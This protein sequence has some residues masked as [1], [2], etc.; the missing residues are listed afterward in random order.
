MPSRS[1]RHQHARTF[2]RA[3]LFKEL[4]SFADLERHIEQL[5]TEKE[6]GD[7]FEVFVEAYLC[8]DEMAQAEEVWVVGQIPG[9]VARQLNFPSKDYGFDGVV[10]TKLGEL[11]PYQAKFRTGRASLPYAELATFFGITE[12]A[13]R[14][15][16]LTNSMAISAVAESRTGFQTTRGGDFDR[17]DAAQLA[18]IAAWIDGV[19]PTPVIREPRPHQQAALAEIQSELSTHDRA[20]V[21]MAC[22]T[23]KTLV[24]LWAAERQQP[25]RVLVLVPSLSLLRQTLHEWAKWTN[26]G[27]R[28]RYLC[29]C[30]D[31]KVAKGIDEIEIRPEDADFPVMTDPAVVGRFLDHGEG[32]VSVVFCTYQSA[33]VVGAAMADRE[34][35]DLGIFDEAHKTT[36][37]EGTRFAFALRDENLPIR[38][39][40]FMTAT[41]RHYDIR[42]RDKE[43][44]FAVASMDDE[45]VYGRVAHRL[46]FANAA[47]QKI[48]VPY[49]VV[50]SVVDSEMIDNALLDQSEVVING[51]PVR[52]KWV[53]HQI[54]LKRAV[55]EH[56]LK[57]VISF[58]SS[59]KAAVE[60]ASDGSA[61]VGTH[62]PSFQRFHV[63]GAQPTAEREEHMREFARVQRGVITN[64]RCLTEGVD[65]PSVDMVAFM[66]PRRSRVDIVQAVG[67]AMR[68]AGLDKTCGYVLI[69]LFLETRK[70]ESLEEALERSDFDEVAQVLNAMRESDDDLNDI[71]Q[72]LTVDRGRIG[73]FDESRLR[74]KLE[75]LGPQL[76][77]AELAK[78]VGI[79]LV[80][81]LGVTWDERYGQLIAYK[82]HHGTCNVPQRWKLVQGLGAW[83]NRQRSDCAKGDLS[84]D[85][86]ERLDRLGFEWE[87]FDV[88]WAR[89]FE[90]LV[91]YKT[92]NGNLNVPKEWKESPR[93]GNWCSTQRVLYSR[94]QLSHSRVQRLEELGFRWDTYGDAWEKMFA[95]LVAYKQERGN[96]NVSKHNKG[97][98]KLG[99]WCVTQRRLYSKHKLSPACVERLE[100]LG[101]LW[102]PFAVA[103]ERMLEALTAY[104][105]DYGNC[106]VPRSFDGNRGLGAWCH[107][108][109]HAYK[110]GKLPSEYASRLEQLGFEW[111]PTQS[112]WEQMFAALSAYKAVHGN[113]DVPDPYPDNPRLGRWC[114]FQ[115]HRLTANKLSP[116]RVKRLEQLG[117]SWDPFAASW[118]EMFE[119]LIAFWQDHG[120]CAV[121]AHW[122]ENR[123]LGR[124]CFRQRR[125]WRSNRLPLDRVQRLEQVGFVFESLGAP[126][127][128]MFSTLCAYKQSHGDCDVPSGLKTNPRLASWCLKQRND[129]ENNKLS[130]E[131]IKR[132]EDVGF[133]LDVQRKRNR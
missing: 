25:R 95:E 8:T 98:A 48:I 27:E 130:P 96:C 103:W 85:R 105:R 14:R 71:I 124:W 45:A 9:E 3:G 2:A 132:L 4:G 90:E 30:S 62:L 7:A 120:N 82:T 23:G 64:A 123:S 29:V 41:P 131:R 121:P 26:W 122:K 12:K 125:L 92:I 16:V 69:P 13:D 116:D 24:A 89:M 133:R 83:C 11:V 65:V 101:F 111:N 79:R 129:Y 5:P 76:H 74:D 93:L 81:E 61:G 117:F 53:A 38:K 36:G 33:P 78:S 75:V 77:L 31:P 88:A 84:P 42:K 94:E 118:E 107:N 128:K 86:V 70:G 32:A 34:P 19:K 63:S 55:E 52:A 109:R 51:D 39:R 37:R 66:N 91:A 20:T 104:K 58:H 119:A 106:N 40:L 28:F 57:R 35:F 44:D 108:Q 60:F 18:A 80:E 102:D 59:I 113:C 115:R 67:R 100:R 43:G 47:A 87:P 6:R 15:V 21:V 56:D 114:A 99:A 1:P 50:I 73:S 72:M 54:A 126:W 10:R 22:G 97:T 112:T 17:L 68:T 49:K 46:T 110:N 127:E